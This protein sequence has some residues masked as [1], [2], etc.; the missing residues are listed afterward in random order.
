[1]KKYLPS[2]ILGVLGIIMAVAAI[3]YLTVSIHALPAFMG[4]HHARGHYHTRGAICGLIAFVLIALAAYL[5]LRK[6][7]DQRAAQ[8][9]PVQAKGSDTILGAKDGDTDA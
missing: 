5:A 2:I 3:E 9:A 1:M 8:S 7:A 4:G 6:P